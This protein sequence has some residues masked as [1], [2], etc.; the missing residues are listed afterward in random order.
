MKKLRWPKLPEGERAVLEV[1]L[2]A[3][4]E[5]VERERI[6]EVSG[7]KRSTRDAYISRLKARHLIVET[8]PGTIR[9]TDELFDEAS[10]SNQPGNPAI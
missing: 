4:G 2:E 7:Y 3:N 8:G 5:P 1:L 6:S 9:A 10:R